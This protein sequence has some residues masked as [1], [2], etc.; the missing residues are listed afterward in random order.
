[1]RLPLGFTKPIQ[2]VWGSL[3]LGIKQEG[4]ERDRS[5]PANAEV[6]K[7]WMYMYTSTPHIISW[8][9]AL[10]IKH[11]DTFTFTL[12]QPHNTGKIEIHYFWM[13][14]SYHQIKISCKPCVLDYLK[15]D[16]DDELLNLQVQNLVSTVCR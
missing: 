11:E 9:S 7:T 1:L 6:K 15:P 16:D 10:L 12:L 14:N 8:C 4:C 3:P 5:P 2:W 13:I